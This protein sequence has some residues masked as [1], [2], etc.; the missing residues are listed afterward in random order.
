[1][2]PFAPTNTG[3]SAEGRTNRSRWVASS[4]AT[5]GGMATARTPTSLLGGPSSLGEEQLGRGAAEEARG[6]D[7]RTTAEGGCTLTLRGR[8][9]PRVYALACPCWR[10][11]R[12]ASAILLPPWGAGRLTA[13]IG[14]SRVDMGDDRSARSQLDRPQALAGAT[15]APE[16]R[17]ARQLCSPC[18]WGQ[19]GCRRRSRSCASLTVVVSRR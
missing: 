2:A 10:R 14:L 7:A 19:S 9:V 6:A 13:R 11:S 16:G 18:S 3:A 4:T 15:R 12:P 17:D 8:A 1:M 5:T